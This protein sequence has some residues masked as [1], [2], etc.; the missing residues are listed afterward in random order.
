MEDAGWEMGGGGWGVRLGAGEGGGG[1]ERGKAAGGR[2]GISKEGVEVAGREELGRKRW[3]KQ[4]RKRWRKRQD[5]GNQHRQRNST[6]TE[7]LNTN[8]Q[9]Q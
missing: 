5:G 3:R 7:E 4:W 6:P 2:A 8:R 9:P 1:S